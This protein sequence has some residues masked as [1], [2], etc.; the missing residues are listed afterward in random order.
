MLI[1]LRGKTTL[2]ELLSIIQHRC[3]AL[4]LPDSGILSMAYYLDVSFPIRVVSLWADP[5]HGILKQN[6]SSPNPQLVHI[7]LVGEHRDLST[8]S[9]DQVVEACFPREKW[10]PMQACVRHDEV[11]V[12][13]SV[14][15]TACV[16][17]AGGQGSRLNMT[18]PKGLFSLKNKSLFQHLVDKV[19]P[20]MPI[21]IMTSPLNHDETVRYFAEHKQFGKRISFFCQDML[22][23]LDENYQEIGMGPD[24]NGGVYQK[25]VESGILAS[26]EQEKIDTV[27]IV[28]V[29]NPL[30]DPAD[31]RL[32][33]YHRFQKADVTIKCIERNPNESMGLIV[34]QNGLLKVA[35]YFLLQQE[36][37]GYSYMGQLALSTT[38]IRKAASLQAPLH[39]VKKKL[40]VQAHEV[41]A[42]KRER[43]LFDAFCVADKT[44]ALCYPRE[45]CY[46]PI[47]GPE[48]IAAA[49][50]AL[51]K[52]QT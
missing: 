47:K 4:V 31:G 19:P 23:L 35:E 34:Q 51:E 29:E 48:S 5:R 42:W 26:W 28:P 24:G 40:P 30:A 27:L 39:W 38:F 25:L 33:S 16:I 50:Q 3:S 52:K 8:V 2:F 17:L 6:V 49:E 12:T 11:T 1:D 15:K 13:P 9:A 37:S 7:P 10:T 36:H 45:M 21:A 41:W 43:F 22:P 44:A 18:G 14:N 46:A 20:S 32:V